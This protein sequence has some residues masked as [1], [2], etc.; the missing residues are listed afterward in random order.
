MERLTRQDGAGW[1]VPPEQWDAAVARLAAFE[2]VWEELGAA[3][4][5]VPGELAAL[6]AAGREKTV[7]YRELIGAKLWLAETAAMFARHGL[8]VP[9][10]P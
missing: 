5:G 4:E 7:R 10:R 1:T 6:K 9:P 2:D 8:P 3:L